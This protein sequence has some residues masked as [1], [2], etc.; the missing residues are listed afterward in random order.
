MVFMP[1]CTQSTRNLLIERFHSCAL[2]PAASLLAWIGI[3]VCFLLLQKR[4]GDGLFCQFGGGCNTV[5]SSPYAAMMGIPLPWLG[6]GVYVTLLMLLLL[7]YAMGSGP[8]SKRMLDAVFF[9]SLAGLSVSASLMFIQFVLL[10]SFCLLC[11]ISA[12]VMTSL[13]LVVRKAICAPVFSGSPGGA[14]TLAGFACSSVIVL[15]LIARFP[16]Q[17]TQLDLSTAIVSGSA[18]AKVQL[19]VFSDFECPI[20]A[21]LAKV[22]ERVRMEYPRDVLVAFRHFPLEEHS[23]AIPA[24]VAA[25]CAAQQGAFWQYHDA[26]F[27]DNTRLTERH[28]LETAEKLG[29]DR[30]QF[31]ACLRSEQARKKVESSFRDA[32][33]NG[34]PGT[35]VLFLNGKMIGGLVEFDWLAAEIDK[36]LK[37]TKKHHEPAS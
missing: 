28:F 25:E 5:L 12:A 31:Q 24:A 8:V 36:Q 34:L 13:F 4:A 18:D 21:K 7:A 14:F 3:L 23:Q 6:L 15:C 20:C 30:Q 29:L 27:A 2:I 37:K 17:A 22:I 1:Y 33:N 10:T 19:I 11:T 16:F 26:L 32:M 35:P 9:L